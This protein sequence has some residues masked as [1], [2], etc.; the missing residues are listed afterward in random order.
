M[1]PSYH[2]TKRLI[3]IFIAV[4]L[5]LV[6]WPLML[7][8]AVAVGLDS[9][10]P[11]LFRQKRLGKGQ[12]CFTMYKFRSMI[13]GAEQL[14]TGNVCL[15]G[16]DRITMV[17]R[18]LRASSLDELPQL[19]NIIKGDMSFVGPRPPLTYYPESYDR[20]Q[21]RMFEVRPGITGW[22][23]INGRKQVPWPR[24]IEMNIYYVDNLSFGFDCRILLKTI[25]RVLSN[26]DNHN[27]PAQLIEK[28]KYEPTE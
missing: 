3:D 9:R 23:Q 27:V 17:G 14:G 10:G 18:F 2:Q 6:L 20:W 11:V 5:L 28:E 8:I 12:K 19:F 4:A 24:R 1:C 7:V 16:D 13:V 25:G 22:A 15:P 21:M 26:A